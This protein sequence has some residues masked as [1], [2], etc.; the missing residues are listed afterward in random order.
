MNNDWEPL[1]GIK[2]DP[3]IWLIPLSILLTIILCLF[4][5]YLVF[6]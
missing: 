5:L 3:W 6:K 1:T 4:L 2:E